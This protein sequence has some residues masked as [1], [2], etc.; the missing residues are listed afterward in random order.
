MMKQAIE[1]DK[2][3]MTENARSPAG[4]TKISFLLL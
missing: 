3:I 1:V 4:T 2:Y